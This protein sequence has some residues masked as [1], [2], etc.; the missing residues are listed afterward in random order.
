MTPS[1]TLNHIPILA[2]LHKK[3]LS[4]WTSLKKAMGWMTVESVLDSWEEREI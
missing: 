2:F 4:V 3:V 1:I